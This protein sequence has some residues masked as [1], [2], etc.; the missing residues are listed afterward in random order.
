MIYRGR[1]RSVAVVIASI[2]E[3]HDML[4]RAMD[5]VSAQTIGPVETRVVI[6]MPRL[7]AYKTALEVDAEFVTWLDDDDYMLP[8]NLEVLVEGQRRSGADVVYTK[9]LQRDVDGNE[10]VLGEDVPVEKLWEWDYIANAFMY[11]TSLVRTMGGFPSPRTS[12]WGAIH[13]R[14]MELGARF[15]FVDVEE[16]TLIINLHE[17]NMTNKAEAME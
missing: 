7:R 16:P 5:S 9:S 15:H 1:N 2:P 17:G 10:M 11:R 6:G 14:A 3:R 13:F 8:N 4:L 12:P